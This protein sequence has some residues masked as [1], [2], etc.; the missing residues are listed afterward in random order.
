MFPKAKEAVDMTL[1]FGSGHFDSF[2]SYHRTLRLSPF[3]SLLLPDQI[4]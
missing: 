3:A 2:G 1:R 4:T